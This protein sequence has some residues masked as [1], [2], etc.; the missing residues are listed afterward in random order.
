MEKMPAEVIDNRYQIVTTINSGGMA[1]VYRARDNRLDRDVA[2]K[3]MHSHLAHNPKLVSRFE[4]EAKQ[5]A[6]LTHPGIVQ[7]FDQGT[8]RGRAYLVME[9][10][11]GPNLRHLLETKGTLALGRAL[12]I[13][14]EILAALAAAHRQQ[15]IHRDV[16]P[17]NILISPDG[18]VKVADFGLAHAISQETGNTTG[19]V[20]GTVA[21][22]APEIIN[23]DK[24]DARCD[25]YSV[26]M[27]LYELIT[28]RPPLLE[29]TPIR[30]IWAHVNAEA[31]SLKETLDWIPTEVS[32]LVDA[33][34]ARQAANRPLDAQVAGE[35]LQKVQQQLTPEMLGRSADPGDSEAETPDQKLTVKHDLTG[36]TLQSQTAILPA[37]S[38]LDA[39][40]G[41]G[42]AAGILNGALIKGTDA[43]SAPNASAAT[44]SAGQKDFLDDPIPAPGVQSEA[45]LLSVA[46]GSEEYFV[47]GD[48]LTELIVARPTA[49]TQNSGSDSA[50]EPDS[51]RTQMLPQV[52]ADQP[53]ET[54]SK[55]AASSTEGTTTSGAL[56]K[57]QMRAA[58][59]QA[60][61]LDKR[62][63]K[64]AKR[65]AKE[66][67][68]TTLATSVPDN[69]GLKKKKV[70]KIWSF[71]L[72]AILLIG[73]LALGYWWFAAGPGSRVTLPEVQGLTQSQAEE[74]LSES[75]INYQIET[76]YSDTVEN[77]Y[78][79]ET[80]PQ[81]GQKVY[82]DSDVVRLVVSL[83]IQYVEIPAVLGL[84]LDEAEQIL[85]EE[86]LTIGQTDYEY[87]EEVDKD[88]IIS[89]SP[90]QG[91][92]VKHDT[93]V[94]VVVSKGP[95]PI[96][97]PDLSG[98][99]QDEIQSALESLRLQA[100]FTT[101][102][103]DTVARGQAISQDV[104]AGET[105][106]RG[107]TITVTIS[108]G[109]EMVTVPDLTGQSM[110]AA[111]QQLSEL[112]FQVEVRK[113]LL[114]AL[115]NLVYSQSPAGGTQAKNGSTVV[116]EY[117]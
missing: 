12:E 65:A 112:G 23:Q 48:S 49:G 32:D 73:L 62:Q 105:R 104:A 40:G 25:I 67:G 42:V 64:D 110:D 45:A 87:S 47:S 91:E 51:S 103:S 38:G 35:L 93:S 7:I 74:I 57:R 102:Y 113:R 86:T 63:Q 19:S 53:K 111:K 41:L 101:G 4:E 6:R 79:I 14:A 75:E 52:S 94:Q 71:S 26:G 82:P 99:T 44:G 66:S 17:E 85:A 58:K 109:P 55:D 15:I 50:L 69:A 34:C 1:S 54:A 13:S 98:K 61:K 9:F 115:P 43:V 78:V 70:L 11:N 60:R 77:G 72:L 37:K 46:E 30:T 89:V 39:L 8:W 3:L 106:Y 22:L 84:S 83:G 31:P 108:L 114:G 80:D 81:A 95:T 90:N 27:M 100:S 97:V 68:K 76:I 88:L 36:T 107:D 59:K 21:Y 2:L 117:V 16:K 29:D 20:M 18:R 24:S 5:T 116:L 10:V 28:G 96:E 92:S 56:T 33:L